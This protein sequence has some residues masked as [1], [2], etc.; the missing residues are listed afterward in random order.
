MTATHSSTEKFNRALFNL[1]ADYSNCPPEDPERK[2]ALR[3]DIATLRGQAA[4]DCL[5]FSFLLFCARGD[6]NKV[7]AELG[8]TI[9]D[10]ATEEAPR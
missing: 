1:A 3:A 9:E 10:P 5:L 2:E 4:E 6:R 8:E 7:L